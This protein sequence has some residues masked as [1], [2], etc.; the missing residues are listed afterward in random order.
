LQ[1]IEENRQRAL[2]RQRL[3]R[4]ADGDAKDDANS[5]PAQ[6]AATA[7]A[8]ALEA[9]AAP[10]APEA[11]AVPA[12]PVA[13]VAPAAPA[14]PAPAPAAKVPRKK[15]EAGAAKK[16]PPRPPARQL[17]R[18]AEATA[19]PE[20]TDLPL[21]KKPACATVT[22]KATSAV[23][24]DASTTLQVTGRE[25]ESERFVGV[26]GA[27]TWLQYNDIYGVRLQKMRDR[28]LAEARALWAGQVQDWSGL[29]QSG[30]PG[31]TP[32]QSS[33]A[34]TVVV[35]IVFKEMP[36]RTDVI[37]H[38]KEHC[39]S[40]VLNDLD[41]VFCS[42]EDV[43][44]LEDNGRARVRLDVSADRVA[45]LVTGLICAFKGHWNEAQTFT[46][47]AWCFAKSPSPPPSLPA[48][49]STAPFVAL[50]SGLGFGDG[51]LDA[52]LRDRSLDFLLAAAKGSENLLGGGT[53]Q[54][55]IVC[56]DSVDMNDVT[57]TKEEV[58]AAL[59][60]ADAFF[61]KLVEAIQVDVMPGR[62][63]MSNYSLPQ[64]PL[65]PYLFAKVRQRCA[66]RSVRNPYEVAVG[67]FTI[68]GTSGQPVHDMLRCSKIP[69][70]LDALS[71]CCEASHLAP[72]APDTLAV[73]PFKDVDPF[74]IGSAPHLLFSGNHDCVAHQWQASRLGGGDDER[75]GT[76]CVIVPAFSVQPS[77]V[78]VNMLDPRDVRI[79]NFAPK[80]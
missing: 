35:G 53:V 59:A 56:G 23:A 78:L 66:F 47:S 77:V 48:P 65:H 12:A 17:F 51:K 13:S 40:Q 14:A 18:E 69:T 2:E 42:D 4:A 58:A 9:P 68:L 50:V 55:L 76:Q 20:K 21:E 80:A 19:T 79:Q 62:K 8:T 36:K 41:Q 26:N 25:A 63:D 3:K 45:S 11:P 52:T 27:A 75:A 71:L 46:A 28:V 32:V 57:R 24:T 67:G 61:D 72:T 34:P 22:A 64:D 54:R 30:P 44:W 60:E 33:T 38:F 7:L 10:A 43:L 31:T 39:S 29:P 6:E 49:T 5:A 15:G 74:V 16:T 37:K 70:A 73:H 1:R